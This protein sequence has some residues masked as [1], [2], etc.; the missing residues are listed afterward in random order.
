MRFQILVYKND[1]HCRHIAPR[2]CRNCRTSMR[3]SPTAWRT[4]THTPAHTY[5]YNDDKRM[6]GFLGI[7]C[8]AYRIG[9]TQEQGVGIGSSTHA[10]PHEQLGLGAYC[11]AMSLPILRFDPKSVRGLRERH[12]RLQSNAPRTPRA[13]PR[14]D[15]MLGICVL[16]RLLIWYARHATEMLRCAS[17][18]RTATESNHFGYTGIYFYWKPG[19]VALGCAML[20]SR[21]VCV[22]ACVLCSN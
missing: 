21:S 12:C 18:Q 13:A 4:H 17:R 22:C 9:Q 2:R 1:H 8:A 11:F 3:L 5:T 19:A 14:T 20:C 7:L 15:L 10:V 16:R 6:N